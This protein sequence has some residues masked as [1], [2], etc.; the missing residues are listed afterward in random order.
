M[1]PMLVVMATGVAAM[2][3]LGVAPYV[4]ARAAPPGTMPEPATAVSSS[5]EVPSAPPPT[6]LPALPSPPPLLPG[7]PPLPALP[8]PPPLPVPDLGLPPPPAPSVPDLPLPDL[9]PVVVPE[10]PDLSGLLPD[11]PGELNL[12]GLPL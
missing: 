4:L 2:V 5:A 6:E 7:L 1:R 8:A 3:Q 11:L 9:P 10:L 12:L